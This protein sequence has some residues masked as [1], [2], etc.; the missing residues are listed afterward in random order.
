MSKSTGPP[1][2]LSKS[3]ALG[4]WRPSP[5]PSPL[6]ALF[7]VRAA[8]PSVS[9]RWLKHT[10]Q[11]VGIPIGFQNALLCMYENVSTQTLGNGKWYRQF[12]TK[13][14]VLQGCP[15]SGA[16][17]VAILDP[18]LRM[19]QQALDEHGGTVRACADDVAAVVHNGSGLIAIHKV[20]MKAQVVANL[21]LNTDRGR[22][23]HSGLRA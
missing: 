6:V 16:L 10:V 8:F 14:G 1:A 21:S 5:G 19:M 12:V 11:S 4:E 17:F 3:P 9:Q 18:F 13:S 2:A 23:S 22:I 15:H 20:F 7:D